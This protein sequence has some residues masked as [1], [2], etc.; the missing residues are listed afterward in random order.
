VKNAVDEV[1]VATIELVATSR[2][3]TLSTRALTPFLVPRRGQHVVGAWAEVFQHPEVR[4][5]PGFVVEVTGVPY[6]LPC[7]GDHRLAR[8]VTVIKAHD[9]ATCDSVVI[10]DS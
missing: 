10:C 3:L 2:D 1:C 9:D 8:V 7:M 4:A 5:S 6:E